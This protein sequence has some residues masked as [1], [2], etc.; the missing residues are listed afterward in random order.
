MELVLLFVHET[1][2]IPNLIIFNIWGPSVS[3]LEFD[4]LSKLVDYLIFNFFKCSNK[5]IY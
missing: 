5:F 3:D 2:L 1:K 4:P